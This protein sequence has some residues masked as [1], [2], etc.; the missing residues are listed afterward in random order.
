MIDEN[1]QQVI[2][3]Y[4]DTIPRTAKELYHLL[5]IAAKVVQSLIQIITPASP[6]AGEVK[7]DQLNLQGKPL[8]KLIFRDDRLDTLRQAL[9]QYGVDYSVLPSQEK[10]GVEIW[11]KSQDINRIESAVQYVKD[12]LTTQLEEPEPSLEEL[13]TSAREKVA[14]HNASI[15]IPT[16]EKAHKKDIVL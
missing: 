12:E 14:E 3:V 4:T 6:E 7:M 9:H 8:E 1:S 2:R 11:F 13:L 16:P 10:D 15:P 5:V